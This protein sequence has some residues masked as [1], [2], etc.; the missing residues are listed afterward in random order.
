MSLQFVYLI[1]LK[2]KQRFLNDYKIYLIV[3]YFLRQVMSVKPE[4]EK[5]IVFS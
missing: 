5:L 4:N 2:H 3:T 1:N